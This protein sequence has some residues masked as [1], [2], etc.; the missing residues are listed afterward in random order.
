MAWKKCKGTRLEVFS[1][2]QA[3]LNR[4]I[5]LILYSKQL[6][7]KYDV[8]LEIKSMKGFRHI[9]SKTV[10]RRID[11]LEK[12]GWIA[13]KGTRPAK[14]QGDSVLYELTL[15]GKAALRLY[16]KSVEEFL[17]TATDEQLLKFL[18]IL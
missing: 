4:V 13:R 15:K 8:F 16:E 6:L 1:D 12:E 11:A 14:V 18:N 5:L 7:A 10:Y 3:C 2:K 17:Q 9:D